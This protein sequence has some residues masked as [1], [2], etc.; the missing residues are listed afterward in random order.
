MFRISEIVLT[1]SIT[2]KIIDLNGE[3]IEWSY[4][5]QELQKPT[6]DILRIEEVLKRN[7]DKA[8]VIWVGYSDA[9]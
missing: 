6:Q 2:Y 8:L 5:E 7:G 3:E 4:Y 1:I 9:F